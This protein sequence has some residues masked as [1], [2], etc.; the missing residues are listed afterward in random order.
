ME[1]LHT[2]KFCAAPV[3]QQLVAAPEKSTVL[4]PNNLQDDQSSNGAE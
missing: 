2:M 3:T 4:F 1:H